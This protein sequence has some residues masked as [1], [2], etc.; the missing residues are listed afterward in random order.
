[1]WAVKKALAAGIFVWAGLAGMSAWAWGGG[2]DTVGLSVLEKVGPKWESRLKSVS[3]RRFLEAT[4]LPDNG[5]P[6]L[7]GEKCRAY[8]VSHGMG[9]KSAYGLHKPPLRMA[10]FNALVAAMV[11]NRDEDVA[12]VTAALSHALAD[13]YACNHDPIAHYATYIVSPGGLD[14]VPSLSL[15]FRF[16]GEEKTTLARRLAALEELPLP[17]DQTPSDV[18]RQIDRWDFEADDLNFSHGRKAVD[19]ELVYC[20]AKTPENAAKLADVLCDLGLAAVQHTIWCFRAAERFAAAGK[21]LPD[22]DFA[23]LAAAHER[24]FNSIR[25]ARDAHNDAFAADCLP[26]PGRKYEIAVLYDPL[27]HM[28]SGVLSPYARLAAVQ[29][30]HSLRAMGRRTA[31]L[32]IR[33]ARKGVDAS[34]A[35]ALI[36]FGRRFAGWAGFDAGA[37]KTAIVRYAKDGGRIVWIDGGIIPGVC[38]GLRSALRETERKDGYCDPKY[39]VALGELVRSELAW[40]GVGGLKSWR[41]RRR[42]NGKAGWM[43]DGSRWWFDPAKLPADAKPVLELRTPDHGVFVQGVTLGNFTYLPLAAIFPYVF[44]GERPDLANGLGLRLDSCGEEILRRVVG[45]TN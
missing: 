34:A 21:P 20:A 18:Y 32:D 5:D 45:G 26:E 13:P 23:A 4:H 19:A 41:C 6:N 2:H 8:L 11:D 27:G 17:A 33:E 28:A 1:M 37:L 38:D 15:D 22:V 30:V 9:G 35:P 31:L 10:L 14:V 29:C 44:T 7:F 16:A 42:P 39:P 43:W 25:A 36:V 24:E 3:C 12:I 40:T